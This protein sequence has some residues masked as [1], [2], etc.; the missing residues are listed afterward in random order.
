MGI[1]TTLPGDLAALDTEGIGE[2]EPIWD[3]MSKFRITNQRF[4]RSFCKAH[5]LARRREPRPS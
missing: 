3:R 4:S 2:G 5:T 1:E